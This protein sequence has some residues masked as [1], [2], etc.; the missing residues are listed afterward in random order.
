ME[1]T[2]LVL[3]IVAILF[4]ASFCVAQEKEPGTVSPHSSDTAVDSGGK[5]RVFGRLPTADS[6]VEI[7]AVSHP[8]EPIGE[9]NE[10][11]SC[12]VSDGRYETLL[13]PG[14]YRLRVQFNDTATTGAILHVQDKEINRDLVGLLKRPAKIIEA[15]TKNPFDTSA[16]PEQFAERVAQLEKDTSE[17]KGIVIVGRIVDAQGQ[18][19]GRGDYDAELRWGNIFYGDPA[20]FEGGWFHTRNFIRQFDIRL[21]EAG[22]RHP[23][24]GETAKLYVYTATNEPAMVEI[25]IELGTVHYAEIVLD[26]TLENEL[27]SLSG[28]VLD[29]EGQP[30]DG[31]SV[32]IRC[33][34]VGSDMALKR[35]T[36]D[37]T[38]RFSFEKITPQA[39]KIILKKQGYAYPPREIPLLLLGDEHVFQSRPLR[40]VEIEY[41]YQPDG[42]PDFTKGNIQ[43]QTVTLVQDYNRGLHFATAQL[44]AGSHSSRDINFNNDREGRLVF[45]HT[46]TNAVDNRFYDAGKVLFESVGKADENP[47]VPRDVW[48]SYPPLPVKLDH[49]YVVKTTEGKYAKF[50]VRK[51][52]PPLPANIADAP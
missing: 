52:T 43:P 9:L 38:G 51:I 31:V 41:V 45:T 12:T 33:N 30:V 25:P 10:Q 21:I 36:T 28:T 22:E 50:V 3:R 49:V 19:M 1:K 4:A 27:V 32:N 42:S 40:S 20:S 15:T 34:G 24:W 29:E 11:F 46:Y 23:D 39:Y 18:P 7:F 5:V 26:K 37:K 48:G 35:T 6:Q 8:H 17:N 13:P 47:D 16:F 2:L 14:W 44:T